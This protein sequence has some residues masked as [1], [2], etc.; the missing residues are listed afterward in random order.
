[1]RATSDG[2][3]H[4]PNRFSVACTAEPELPFAYD[5]FMGVGL[6]DGHRR[7]FSAEAKWVVAA[8]GGRGRFW[9]SGPVSEAPARG[10]RTQKPLPKGLAFGG[11]LGEGLV[12]PSAH[13]RGLR[14]RTGPPRPA[15]TPHIATT[16]VAPAETVF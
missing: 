12:G 15:S 11:A 13:R 1:M 8:W 6:L 10:V 9:R 5:P 14:D 16:H 3:Q 4:V 7:P 2:G